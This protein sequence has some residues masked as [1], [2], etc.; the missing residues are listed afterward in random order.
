MLSGKHIVLGVTGGIAAYKAAPIVS[1]LK[2]QGAEVRVV[3]T[4]NAHQFITPLTLETL[5]GH[6]VYTDSFDRAWE[7]GHISLAKWADLFVIAPATANVLGKIVH[8][9]ADDLLTTAVMASPVGLMI[10]PAMNTVMWLSPANQSNIRIL[11]ERGALMVGPESGTLA[12]KDDDIGRMSEPETIVDRIGEYFT[13]RDDFAGRRVL[14]TAGPTREMLDPV[15]FL[16]NRS[17]GKMGYAIAE[18]V[19]DRGAAVT[20]VSGPVALT[21]P[22][23]VELVSI[24]SS[25]DLHREVTARAKQMDVVIQAAAPADYTPVQYSER[26]IKKVGDDLVVALK[27]TVDIAAELGREKRAGQVL[28]AFAAETNNTL[29]NARE[30]RIRKNADLIVLNDVTRPGAGFEGDTNAVTLIDS[31]GEE[32]VPL[33]HKRQVAMRILDRVLGYLS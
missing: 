20:L 26:K 33:L 22:T 30:K 1:K 10:A 8:G 24:Q 2:K 4:A 9:I 28:V 14:V 19:R 13:S 16:S 27:K 18:A 3:M 11:K 7:I 23:G 12:C 17:S 29:E 31:A 5:S 21:P 15:R 32:E 6:A 25:E